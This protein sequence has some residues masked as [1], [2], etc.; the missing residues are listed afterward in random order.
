MET[1]ILVSWTPE[2]VVAYN[3]G[4]QEL[5]RIIRETHYKI[6]SI[7]YSS[8]KT[9]VRNERFITTHTR[10]IAKSKTN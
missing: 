1:V 6:A 10:Y 3:K 2:D 9:R 7:E 4:I 8:H 5:E